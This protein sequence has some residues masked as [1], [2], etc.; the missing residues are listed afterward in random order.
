MSLPSYRVLVTAS[1]LAPPVRER[2]EST[3]AR[4]E[5]LEDGPSEDQVVAAAAREPLDVL[6]VRN[7]PVI[8]PRLFAAAPDLKVIAKHGAG[9]DSIDVAAATQNRVPLLVAAGANAASVAEMTL[10]LILAIG[11]EMTWHDRRLREGHWDKWHYLGRDVCGRRLGLVG[12]GAIARRVA[13]MAKALGLDVIAQSRRME[14]IDPALAR[15]VPDL[16]TLLRESDIVSLHCPYGPA[17]HQ[18]INART[19]ALMKKDALLIN[20]ARGG[21][22]DEDALCR[23]LHEGVIAGAALDTFAVEPTPPDN[24]LFQAPNLIVTPHIAAHTKDTQ[25]RT[26]LIA[27]ENIIA[28]LS[29]TPPDHANVVNPEVLGAVRT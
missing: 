7:N 6:L 16:E 3:G 11:R 29:G 9:Y 12:F 15:P 21:L 13:G 4:I 18:M 14:S 5:Y 2:L 28:I 26:G 27:A 25:D 24:P 22:V 19:L 10:A 17:T 23:A 20:T 1:R 8:G